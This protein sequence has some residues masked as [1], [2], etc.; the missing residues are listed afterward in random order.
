MGCFGLGSIEHLLIW[1]VVVAAAF[2]VIRV[3]L[4]L[5][6]PPADF[7]WAVAAAIGIVRII[8][9]AVVTIAIIVVIFALL[10]CVVPLR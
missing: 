3:L 2:A 8:L 4:G 7:A 9:W 5:V 6:S 10:A 1:I